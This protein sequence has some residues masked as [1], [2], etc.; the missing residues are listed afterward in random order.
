MTRRIAVRLSDG[1]VSRIDALVPT[2]HES[3]WDA[4]RHSVELYLFR[5]ASEQDAERYAR[6]PLVEAE[7][8]PVDD[9][10]GWSG[11]PAW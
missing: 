8:D 6:V 5:L 1:L 11:T 9:P 3:R 7:L 10:D 4:I 2:V